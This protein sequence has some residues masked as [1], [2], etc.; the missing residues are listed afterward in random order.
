VSFNSEKEIK[1]REKVLWPFCFLI[2]SGYKKLSHIEK[3]KYWN[4]IFLL[5]AFTVL[6]LEILNFSKL[7]LS[8]YVYIFGISIITLLWFAWVARWRK[9]TSNTY[10]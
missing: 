7:G 2:G 3:I 6:P 4:G 1:F 8:G 9:Y 10:K 5:S